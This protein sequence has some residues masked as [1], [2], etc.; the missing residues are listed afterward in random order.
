MS[1]VTTLKSTLKRKPSQDDFIN[2]I[3]KSSEVKTIFKSE[4]D[5]HTAT[6]SSYELPKDMIEGLNKLNNLPFF[7]SFDLNFR[8][9]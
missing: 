1:A 9:F 8:F 5:S 4:L 7:S 2:E 6:E 3:I